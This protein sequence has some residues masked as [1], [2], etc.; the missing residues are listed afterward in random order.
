VYNDIANQLFP[1]PWNGLSLEMTAW[2]MCLG[3]VTLAIRIQTVVKAM[4]RTAFPWRM[5][6]SV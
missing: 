5:P 3:V 1:C 4:E 6:Q 2:D